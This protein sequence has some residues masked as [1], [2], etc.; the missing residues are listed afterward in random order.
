MGAPPP[1]AKGVPASLAG[2]APAPV[3]GVTRKGDDGST[4]LLFGAKV[5]KSESRTEAYGA[6]D[7]AIAAVGF[8]RA[9]SQETLTKETLLRVQHDLFTV[10]TELAAAPDMYDQ[11][12]EH[13]SP[14]TTEMVARLEPWIDDT[15]NGVD[16]PSSF[17]VPGASKGSAAIDLA[18][19]MVRDA[20]R[21]I[22][23]LDEVEPLTNKE[24][25]RYVNR[26][27]DLLFALARLEDKD[28]PNEI[29]TG[30]MRRDA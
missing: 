1:P 22:V 26:L 5:L 29:T 18:R 9:T 19:T 2:P 30:K 4:E 20:E 8:A 13:F 7:T 23:A 16:L 11:L 25:L 12:L 10:A 14:V 24:L 3:C 17:I 21:R 27:S 15:L 6:V 28:L